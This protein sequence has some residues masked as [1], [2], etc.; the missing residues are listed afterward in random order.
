VRIIA[1]GHAHLI[2]IVG[3]HESRL[4]AIEKRP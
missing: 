4:Q 2:T 3:N 1:E